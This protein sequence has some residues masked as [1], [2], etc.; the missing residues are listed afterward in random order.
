MVI[1]FSHAVYQIDRLLILIPREREFLFTRIFVQTELFVN[2]N[3]LRLLYSLYCHF[4]YSYFPI[5]FL[6]SSRI[7]LSRSN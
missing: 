5:K 6:A 3:L 7:S 2:Q 1:R 4:V